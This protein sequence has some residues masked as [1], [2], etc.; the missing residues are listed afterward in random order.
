MRNYK[1]KFFAADDFEALRAFTEILIPTDE[2][3]G[4]REAYCAHYI[5]FVLQCADSMPGYQKQWRDAMA[6]PERPRVFT[7][8]TRKAGQRWLKRCPSPSATAMPS[9]PHSLPTV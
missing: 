4:A 7:T 2:T 3:P 9:I 1:P 8:P 6:S 5:D